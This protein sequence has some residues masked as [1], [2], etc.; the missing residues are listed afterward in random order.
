LFRKRHHEDNP[1][2][3]TD[4]TGNGVTSHSVPKRVATRSNPQS[5]Y[6][7]VKDLRISFDSFFSST[8]S[9]SISGNYSPPSSNESDSSS[10]TN[11][12]LSSN[13]IHSQLCTCPNQDCVIHDRRR[14]MNVPVELTSTSNPTYGNNNLLLYYAHL[15]RCRR[16]GQNIHQDTSSS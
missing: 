4:S 15:E 6:V 10:S 3:S 11:S 1:Y 12:T 5:K 14:S 9:F 16:H 2:S 8:N 13:S 7:F